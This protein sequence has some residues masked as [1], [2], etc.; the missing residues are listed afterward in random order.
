MPIACQKSIYEMQ[1]NK[2]VYEDYCK[3]QLLRQKADC[4]HGK[5]VLGL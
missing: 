5:V 3:S 4:Y 1:E 2:H